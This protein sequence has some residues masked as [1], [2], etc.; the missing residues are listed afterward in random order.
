MNTQTFHGGI[1]PPENKTQSTQTPIE[2]ALLPNKLILPLQQHIGQQAKPLVS[3]GERVLKGQMIAAAV[4]YISAAVHAPTSGIVTAI[5]AHA[6]PHP[7][8]LSGQCIVIK[9]DGQ[10]QWSEL[11]PLENYQQADGSIAV[12]EVLQPLMNGQ[13][14]ID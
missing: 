8:G 12:P 10:D 1:H 9:P 6:L 11:T 3:P 7:S 5:E 13:T 2:T 14:V 4:G